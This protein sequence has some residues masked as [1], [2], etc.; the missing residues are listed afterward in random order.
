MLEKGISAPDFET[1][2]QF[3][4]KLKLSDFRG[5]KIV[6]YFYPKD[7]TPGC[8][9][10]ACNLR[11][12]YNLLLSRGYVVLGISP[13]SEASHGKFTQKQNLPF[14]ILTDADKEIVN[15]Y[16]VW[17][18]KKMCGRE[19][20]GVVRTTFIIDEEGRIEEVIEKVKVADHAAQIVK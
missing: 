13:D 1:T 6:L 5:K 4:N 10:E 19:Y 7:N 9:Q 17:Q 18:L 15:A 16:G 12:N 8:T 20:M 2:D 3:G 11:D 14:Q